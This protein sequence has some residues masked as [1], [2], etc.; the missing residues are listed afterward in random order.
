MNSL[1]IEQ[2]EYAGVIHNSFQ[3]R[4]QVSNHYQQ[5]VQSSG[6]VNKRLRYLRGTARCAILE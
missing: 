4:Q 2:L 1:H 6:T 3:P 5:N